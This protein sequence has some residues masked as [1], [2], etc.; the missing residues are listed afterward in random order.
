[1]KPRIPLVT[2]PNGSITRVLYSFLS[3]NRDFPAFQ[4]HG[5][6][7][8]LLSPFAQAWQPETGP[9]LNAANCSSDMRAGS[10]RARV[11]GSYCWLSSQHCL[12]VGFPQDQYFLSPELLF[13]FFFSEAYFYPHHHILRCKLSFLE[14]P[15]DFHF[16]PKPCQV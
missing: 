1:M 11:V 7:L 3:I 10:E 12:P 13:F 4:Q 2:R 8:G 5:S 9:K 16:K 14:L 6:K 15:Q